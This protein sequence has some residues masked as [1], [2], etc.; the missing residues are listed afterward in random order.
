MRILHTADWHLGDRLG[1]IDRTAELRR[2]VEP[3]A[4]SAEAEGVEVVLVAGDLFSDRCGHDG[5]RDAIEHLQRTFLPFLRRGGAIVGPTGNPPH[6]GFCQTLTHTLNLGAP[7]PAIQGD[8]VPNGR[9]YL[10]VA[11]SFFRLK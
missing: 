7:A 10:A 3:I 8:L 6:G 1:R 4:P 11:P 5:L 2:A 9:L